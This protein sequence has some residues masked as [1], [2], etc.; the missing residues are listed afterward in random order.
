M[1]WSLCIAQSLH[2][3]VQSGR[4]VRPCKMEHTSTTPSPQNSSLY[5]H[6]K[7][8]FNLPTFGTDRSLICT[9]VYTVI[10]VLCTI[11]S[12]YRKVIRF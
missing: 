12:G 5:A 10:I 7:T 8:S 11:I 3:V 9:Y 2:V 1:V 6:A 4:I